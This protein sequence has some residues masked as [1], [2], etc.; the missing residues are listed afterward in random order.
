[1]NG[2]SKHAENE[3]YRLAVR[4]ADGDT[5]AADELKQELGPQVARIVR[6]ARRAGT[7]QGNFGQQIRLLAN[8]L[9]RPGRSEGPRPSTEAAGALASQLCESLR[10]LP[11]AASRVA[12]WQDTI[13]GR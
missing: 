4:I 10:K 8:R 13:H 5:L 9:S 6:R 3:F 12:P 11:H 1:M 7:H 2:L